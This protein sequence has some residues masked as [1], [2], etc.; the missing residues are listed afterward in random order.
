M[1][2]APPPARA[3]CLRPMPARW[4]LAGLLLLAC[5]PNPAPAPLAQQDPAPQPAAPSEPALACTDVPCWLA[6]ADAAQV[7]GLLDL[8][9]AHRGRAFALA[10]TPAHL[11]A[12]VDGMRSAGQ[13]RRAREALTA[14]RLAAHD[15]PALLAAIDEQLPTLHSTPLAPPTGPLSPALREAYDLAL[16]GAPTEAALAFHT[17][18]RGETRP[19]VLADAASVIADH[20]RGA[21]DLHA[22][23]RGAWARAR[24]Q[25]H[26]QGATL[27]LLPV[28]T[29]MVRGVAWRGDKLVLLRNV[30]VLASPGVRLGLITV[31]APTPDAP[32]RRL[33]APEPA[34]ALALTADGSAVIRGEGPRV[35]VQRLDTGET[36]PPI[37]AG[38]RSARLTS[39]GAG[40]S[41]RTLA[42]VERVVHLWGAAGNT[43]ASFHL[44]G[45]TP[46]ITRAYTGEGTYHHN[47]L[48][49][50]PTWP[51][52]LALAADADTVAIG[53]SDSRVFVFDGL[54]R[55]RHV[56]KF[57]WDYT[58]RRHMGGNPDLNQPLALHLI[59]DHELLAIHNHGDLLRWDLRTGKPI[60]HIA[61]DCDT[62]EATT[63]V[64]RYADPGFPRQVPTPEQRRACGAAQSAAFSRDG[65]MVAT[66][67]I[68]GVRV[69]D[70]SSGAGLA[71]MVD[72]GMPDDMLA[73]APD[74][75]LAMVDLYGAVA[76]WRPGQSPVRRVPPSPSGPVDPFLSRDGRVLHFHEGNHEHLWDLRARA[77]LP[78]ER[79]Q[80]EHIL[81]IAPDG[82]RIVVRHDTHVDL[83]DA[84]TAAQILRTP[85]PIG[86]S[87][88]ARFTP[89]GHVFLDIQGSTRTLL[90]IDP[91]GRGQ[92]IALPADPRSLQLSDD[93]RLL[94]SLDHEAPAQVWRTDTGALVQ[95]LT[96]H[97]HDLRF[98]RDGSAVAWLE[99][100]DPERPRTRA[101]LRRIDAD[102]TGD[103]TLELDGWPTA[104]AL[105]HD[106]AELLILIQSGK[107]WRWR[108]A[109]GSK[110][111]VEELGLFPVRRIDLSDDGRLLLLAG[112]GHV[113]LRRND[114]AITP[115]ATI[116]A[117][118][119]GGWLARSHSGAVDGSPD[120]VASLVTR[121]THGA[122]TRILP[123]ELGWDAAHV[124]HL[125]ARALAGEDVPPPVPGR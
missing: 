34:D 124:P 10:R 37:A 9:S 43:L 106:G 69:R 116:H 68:Q 48:A 66:G 63:V 44:D 28:E 62:T 95:T 77:P 73:F 5:K 27:E 105:T 86:A 42:I 7:A 79:E 100:P 119:D 108:P 102:P 50:S 49:D 40:D 97:T 109:T 41:L 38:E 11:L 122:D 4:T 55:R 52:S 121:V 58:E 59:G 88:Y 92:P 89:A 6:A 18:L 60:E 112:Y 114:D 29:W 70:T 36:S 39:V 120:A 65:R 107:L 56:L 93:G 72:T 54:G 115:L 64:N 14:A 32:T 75:T 45:T 21:P 24:V 19:A 99:L 8:A 113:Q 110:R 117:L 35:V 13:L 91:Q 98:A 96:A 46:T 12:W 61:P 25:L 51:V 16:A 78:L 3:R 103:Q 15:D 85:I 94:A 80:G 57:R 125:V 87:A 111:L 31:A 2:P 67:G 22:W 90:R 23:A 83:R 118:V 101:H 104:L 74:G 81:A 53:G 84:A 76:I 20:A 26:E 30:G 71:M 47:F 82:R 33:F 1:T 123:G 17:L